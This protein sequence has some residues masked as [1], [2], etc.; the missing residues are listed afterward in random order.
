MPFDEIV[1]RSANECTQQI[2]K[3]LPGCRATEVFQVKGF[4]E[5]FLNT[6]R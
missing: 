5:A 1:V 6:N 4:R 3:C 2:I